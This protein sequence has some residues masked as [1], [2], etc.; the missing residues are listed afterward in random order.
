MYI[1]I[2]IYIFKNPKHHPKFSYYPGVERRQF[3]KGT[4]ARLH[5]FLL[6]LSFH[7]EKALALFKTIWV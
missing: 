5:M 3:S 7:N 6:G 1:Y 2:Y 4:C